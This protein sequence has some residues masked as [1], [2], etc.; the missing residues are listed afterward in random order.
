MA[1]AEVS[2]PLRILLVEDSEHDA[3]AFHRAFRKAAA[4]YDIALCERAEEALARLYDQTSSFDLVVADYMLPG[5]SGLDLYRELRSSNISIP[6]VLLT[7]AGAEYLAVE[8]LK[9]GVDDYIIKDASQGYI[10]LLPI[11][12]PE[13]VQRYRARLEHQRLQNALSERESQLRL[14]TDAL[15]VGIS[16]VDVEQCYRF[17]NRTCEV[18]VGQPRT[19]LYGRHV[20]EVWGEE[21]YALTRAYIETAL[22]GQPCACEHVM[23]L[24][25]A[26][27]R[28]FHLMFIPDLDV[29]GHCRGCFTLITDVTKRKRLET[30]LRQAQTMHAIGTLAGGIAHEFNNILMAIMGYTSLV[31]D[32]VPQGSTTWSNIQQ[33]LMAG[34]RARDLVQQILAFSR[35]VKVEHRP[36]KLHLLVQEALGLIRR[37]LPATILLQE[38]VEKNVG[39]VLTSITEVHQIMMNLCANAAHAMREV[40]GTLAIRLDTV[41][42]QG[43]PTSQ[44]PVLRP[45][46]YAW[47][48]IRDTGHGMPP[49]VIEHIFEPFFTTKEVGEGTGMGLAVVHG[50]VTHHGGT[51]TV[52]STPGQGTTFDIYLPRVAEAGTTIAALPEPIV[53]GQGRVL[54]VD[55]DTSLAHLGH[56]MLTSLGYE[57]IACTSGDEALHHFRQT[58]QSFDLVITDQTMPYMTGEVLVQ[59][60]RCIRP[61]IPIILC[62]GYSNSIDV[63][64]ARVQGIEAFLMKPL[65]IDTLAPTIQ[66]LLERREAS[67]PKSQC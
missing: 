12:L 41:E 29:Q 7:G 54:Y 8:A 51:V 44:H 47:L 45:G 35:Q 2:A 13:V 58:P 3:V 38:D 49:D 37:I 62:T 15:P 39:T 46:S 10:N 30:E 27:R 20:G 4:L 1:H 26:G 19:A 21:A 36:T 56:A 31:L 17:A 6:L 61:D 34:E 18:W 28:V 66:R 11:V 22:A 5:M 53:P 16:Y 23:A 14:V 63:D 55:D 33:V 57:V 64:K 9:A 43:P 24:S 59:A 67:P 60:L 25:Q 42:V 52:H 32:D 65:S 48:S 40:G 50:I